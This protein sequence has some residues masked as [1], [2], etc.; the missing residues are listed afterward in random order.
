MSGEAE[1]ELRELVAVWKAE[2]KRIRA[3]AEKERSKS[4]RDSLMAQSVR[5]WFCADE[6]EAVLAQMPSAAQIGPR[7]VAGEDG[8]TYELH[9]TTGA[10][11]EGDAVP[12]TTISRIEV[13]DR[14]A[15]VASQYLAGGHSHRAQMLN[16][17]AKEFLYG[18]S[19]EPQKSKLKRESAPQDAAQI[20]EIKAGGKVSQ[21][22]ARKD[23]A[24]TEM[25]P[26]CGEM[27]APGVK[28]D[29]CN[30]PA[31][32]T[33]TQQ[34]FE[35]WWSK[36]SRAVTCG[37]PTHNPTWYAARAAWGYS[38]ARV[39]REVVEECAKKYS[40]DDVLAAMVRALAEQGEQR[41]ENK[42]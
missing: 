14:L 5:Y 23:V 34:D 12:P 8:H 20:G 9:T 37:L 11:A 26:T 39:R 16:A 36:Y 2:A 7:T 28:C 29:L 3:L 19:K 18:E 21:A 22:E 17:L 25:C 42:A 10:N 31:S 27:Y 6:L 33:A 24:L 35:E 4:S 40:V 15:K 41:K 32:A 38:A 13:H 30:A 1:K